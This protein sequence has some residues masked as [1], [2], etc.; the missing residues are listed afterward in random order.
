MVICEIIVRWLVIVQNTKILTIS[1]FKEYTV[2]HELFQA[3][4]AKYL[5]SALLGFITQGTSLP[6]FRYNPSVHL[7]GKVILD[8]LNLID[9]TDRSSRNCVVLCIVNCVVLC[10]LLNL[11]NKR[12]NSCRVL[13]FSTIFFH[14]T[15]SWVCSD[16]LRSFI[17]LRSFLTSSHGS[18]PFYL[19][20]FLLS[21]FFSEFVL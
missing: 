8:F 5:R 2:T 21:R 20:S 9:W 7:Q 13:A 18:S 10:I 12:Y 6:T 14:S 19:R 3:S 17:L 11:L 4:A 16:H 15:R 1:L